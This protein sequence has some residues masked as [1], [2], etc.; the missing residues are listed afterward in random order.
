MILDTSAVL[1]VI[2][3]EEGHERLIMAMREAP[4]VMIGAPTATE[5]AVVLTRRHGEDGRRAL[6]QF[7]RRNGVVTVPF[8]ATHAGVAV[9][10]SL[11]Y[12]KGRH[13]ARLNFGDCMTYAT[14]KVAGMPLLFIG[15]DFGRTDIAVA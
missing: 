15:D 6:S 2:L 5:C 7:L 1:A 9:D 14:A 10:A 13:R 3:E 4:E 11:R 8:E 12:G